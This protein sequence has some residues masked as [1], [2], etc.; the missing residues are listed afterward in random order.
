MCSRV[1]SL[2]SGLLFSTRDTVPRPTPARLATSRMV[3]KI[4]VPRCSIVAE[5]VLTQHKKSRILYAFG[6]GSTRRQKKRC[7]TFDGTGSIILKFT[8]LVKCFSK[9]HLGIFVVT[10]PSLRNNHCPLELNL[11][12]LSG[13]AITCRVRGINH[14]FPS[15]LYCLASI[16]KL[17]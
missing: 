17:E 2:T 15:K 9:N 16:N 8:E 7:H 10:E 4:C 6:T 1:A 12:S 3:V 5:V 11:T 13:R 14:N